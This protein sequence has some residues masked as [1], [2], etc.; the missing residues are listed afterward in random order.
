M[1]LPEFELHFA[2]SVSQSLYKLR[3]PGS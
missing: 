3:Y 1:P 2:Q